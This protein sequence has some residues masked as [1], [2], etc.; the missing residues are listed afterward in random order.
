[1]PQDRIEGED[2]NAER[3]DPSADITATGGAGASAKQHDKGDE[4]DKAY[5]RDKVQAGTARDPRHPDEDA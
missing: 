3:R 1:M 2:L 5:R 4:D